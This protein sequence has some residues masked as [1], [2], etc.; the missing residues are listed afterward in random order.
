MSKRGEYALEAVH[1]AGTH[2]SRVHLIKK[3]TM[4][5]NKTVNITN[6]KI[7]KYKGESIAT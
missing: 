5:K 1:R 2:G 7:V 4:N 3:R 6:I